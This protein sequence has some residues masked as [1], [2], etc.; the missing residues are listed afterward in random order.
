MI[1]FLRALF[2]LVI[3]SM[4]VVTVRASLDTAIWAIPP[5]VTADKWFQATLA[6]AYFGFL[7]FFVWVA[8]K[9]NSF[10]RSAVW[11][12]L[13]MLLGNIAMASYALIQLFKVDARA[14]LRSVLVRS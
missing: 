7:T 5:M 8:Y 11:F 12:I 4:L 3:I 2:I 1:S 6:D 9:E 10:A 13:I 14:S